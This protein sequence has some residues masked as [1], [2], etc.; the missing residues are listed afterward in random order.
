MSPRIQETE[1][2]PVVS[3]YWEKAEFP[4]PLV[5]KVGA[6]NI[7]GG[8]LQGYGCQGLSTVACGMATIELVS[9]AAVLKWRCSCPATGD[10][11]QFPHHALWG[12]RGFG[13]CHSCYCCDMVKHANDAHNPAREAVE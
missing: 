8:T 12:G 1:I 2:A 11:V 3:E 9:G 13:A 10:W 6:L 4:F 5:P 7:G